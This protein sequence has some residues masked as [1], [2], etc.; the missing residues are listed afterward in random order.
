M[1]RLFLTGLPS[2]QNLSQMQEVWNPSDVWNG[3]APPIK[4]AACCTRCTQTRFPRTHAPTR[5]ERAIFAAPLVS[6]SSAAAAAAAAVDRSVFPDRL[7]LFRRGK[8][9]A[10]HLLDGRGNGKTD[11]AGNSL[12]LPDD[13]RNNF[14]VCQI[15]MG[16]IMEGCYTT[17]PEGSV[18]I[19]F[20]RNNS[21][22]Q[23]LIGQY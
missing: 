12:G 21:L 7:P 9:T 19:A 16:V 1:T 4:T 23:L 20:L 10:A 8:K 14:R 22:F 18:I 6:I 2:H 15:W 3:T 5:C 11:R 17:P 13:A